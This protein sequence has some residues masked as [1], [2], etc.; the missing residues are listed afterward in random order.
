MTRP[1]GQGPEKEKNVRLRTGTEHVV[2]P[3]GAGIW[4]QDLCNAC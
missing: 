2:G 3:T 4:S 1:V